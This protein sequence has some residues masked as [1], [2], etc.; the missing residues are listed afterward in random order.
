MSTIFHNFTLLKTTMES[1]SIFWIE[2]HSFSRPYQSFSPLPRVSR[3]SVR[4][5]L[6]F[7]PEQAVQILHAKV[8]QKSS[9]QGPHRLNIL[10]MSHF[11][12]SSV[13]DPLPGWKTLPNLHHIVYLSHCSAPESW[14]TVHLNNVYILVSFTLHLN[15]RC[16]WKYSDPLTFFTLLLYSLIQKWVK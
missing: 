7:H 15:E 1:L 12:S 11:S 10:Q 13:C 16:E 3:E 8:A 9:L 2:F 4:Q 6:Q 5:Y 14:N